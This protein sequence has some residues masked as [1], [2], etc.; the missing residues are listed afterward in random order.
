MLNIDWTAISVAVAALVFVFDRRHKKKSLIA[1]STVVIEFLA[2]DLIRLARQSR[3]M[4]MYAASLSSWD[5]ESESRVDPY[6]TQR[7]S[8]LSISALERHANELSSLPPALVQR[9]AGCL[10]GI[11]RLQETVELLTADRP[12]GRQYL[13]FEDGKHG[14]NIAAAELMRSAEACL[15]SIDLI[16]CD[17]VT[18]P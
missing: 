9:C 15:E 12:V 18:R 2:Q 13:S 8:E 6:L 17:I 10:A 11:R 7:A 5:H 1:S 4:G 16:R 3:E 14:V